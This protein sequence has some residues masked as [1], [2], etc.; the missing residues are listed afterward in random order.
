MNARINKIIDDHNSD[1][2]AFARGIGVP[3]VTVTR[4]LKGR[5]V[6]GSKN[7][8]AIAAFWPDV[9]LHWLVTGVSK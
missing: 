3:R 1:V 9:C 6:P 2:S 8:A 7:L 4:W 5:S